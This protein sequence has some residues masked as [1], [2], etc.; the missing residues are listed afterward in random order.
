MSY[1]GSTREGVDSNRGP[2]F[3]D[4]LPPKSGG[5]CWGSHPADHVHQAD[6]EL[7]DPRPR[8]ASVAEIPATQLASQSWAL[9]KN[10]GSHPV[11]LLKVP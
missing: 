2:V 6:P 5:S 4:W 1:N 10:P 11:Q 7:G 3:T 9:T 8:T